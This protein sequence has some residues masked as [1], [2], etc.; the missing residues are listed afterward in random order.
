VAF[1]RVRGHYRQ[2]HGQCPLYGE[3]VGCRLVQAPGVSVRLDIEGRHV[4]TRHGDFAPAAQL[5]PRT[6]QTRHPAQYEAT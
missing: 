5:M 2:E 4:E 3:I 1:I 6:C